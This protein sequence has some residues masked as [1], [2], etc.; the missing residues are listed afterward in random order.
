MSSSK[1]Y[2]GCFVSELTSVI[3]LPIDAMRTRRIF[4]EKLHGVKSLYNGF[5]FYLA[6][7]ITKQIA[8]CPTQE[9]IHQKLL[10]ENI[11]YINVVSGLLSGIKLVIVA[12][13]IN[14][15]R[16]PLLLDDATNPF[17]VMKDIYIKEV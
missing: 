8:V 3:F 9:Y 1:D 17:D 6:T 15:I 14:V 5:I 7:T 16:T 13:P 12:T 11:P 2:L 4:D 10:T